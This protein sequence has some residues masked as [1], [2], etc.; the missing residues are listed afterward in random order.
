MKRGKLAVFIS[1]ILAVFFLATQGYCKEYDHSLEVNNMNFS[2]KIDGE[3]LIV[4]LSGKTTGWV[5]IGF[6]PSKRMKDA[7]YVLGFVKKGKA[8]VTDDFGVEE[9]KH[10][11]D[12]KLGGKSDVTLIGGSEEDGMTTVEFSLPLDSGDTKDTVIDLN[13]D[14]TVLLAY[15]GKRDSFISAH[16]FRATLKVNLSTGMFEKIGK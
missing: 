4:K 8:K 3:N 12:E 10:K 11:A 7:N 15:G 2:W 5:G 9:K 6:N 14:T 16:K 13:G 1:G